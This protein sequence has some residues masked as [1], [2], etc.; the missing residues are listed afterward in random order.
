[1]HGSTGNWR[2]KPIRFNILTN[3]GRAIERL[4][5]ATGTSSVVTQLLL[6][7][8]YLSGFQGN[9]FTISLIFFSWLL[10]GGL[11]TWLA[12]F[13]H[14]FQKVTLT[15]LALFSLLLS[16]VSPLEI[17]AIRYLRDL[18]F[19]PG[20]DVGFY[21]TLACIF[22]INMPCGL[23]IGFVLPYSLYILRKL[24]PD[25]PGA[26]LYML[27]NIGDVSGGALFS[28]IL[29]SFFTPLQASFLINIPLLF[30]SFF[31]FPTAIRFKPLY[32]LSGSGA[33]CILIFTLVMEKHSLDPFAGNLVHY[34]ES[35]YGRITVHKDMEQFTLFIDGSSLY[36]SQNTQQAEKSIHY[37]LS[38]LKKPEKILLIA[39]ESGSMKE[40][41]K[42]S[43]IQIDYLEIDKEVVTA[44]FRFNLLY[45]I[46]GLNTIHQDGR[47]F[48]ATTDKQYDAIILNLPEPDTFQINRFYTS[49]FFALARKRLSPD[50]I[51]SF[52]VEGYDNYLAEAPQKKISSLYKT[53]RLHFNEVLLLPGNTV[54]FLCSA[55]QL[56]PDI[57]TLLQ[58]KGIET[59]YIS[60]LFYGNVTKLRRDYLEQKLLPDIAINSDTSP[61]LLQV[62]FQQWFSRFNTSPVPFFGI[63]FMLLFFYLVRS[64]QEELV[65]FTTGFVTM[66][67]ES[68]IIL[69]YQ[70]FFGYVYEQ[71]GLLV[72]VFLLGLLP[73]AR[74][75]EYLRQKTNNVYYLLISDSVLICC[76][77]IFLLAL[78]LSPLLLQPF[79]LFS[80]VF[81]ISVLCGCQFP[82]A[83]SLGGNDNPAAVRTFSADLIGAAYGALVTSLV[84]VPFFGI[85][86][87]AA[88]LITIKIC[89]FLL[90]RTHSYHDK[91]IQ[92]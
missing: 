38:Q 68:L 70:I 66:G 64:R 76:L 74:I 17:L 8:E 15:R 57:P 4:V 60:S 89:S 16:I 32:V 88:A 54:F 22:F 58:E 46:P 39:A 11:G 29:V 55:R 3:K 90:L 52:K 69:I 77:S 2:Y 67:S 80:F 26:R 21:P 5:I 49:T 42:Y 19:I 48:L 14:Q 37:P 30:I 78:V 61:F 27:D 9:E 59:Q 25:Y 23:L 62:M 43:G 75:G 71:I 36:S 18:L 34:Q 47:S 20:M 84:L 92:C 79:V 87:A 10:L 24:D 50:G 56:D 83:F 44:Q 7:R 35:R 51:L 12:R 63:T 73:G 40:L 53:A 81:I 13:V 65:L 31:S 72:T 6:V 28:F 33:F 91:V 86:W 85:I 82:L 1:M 45:K 41:K